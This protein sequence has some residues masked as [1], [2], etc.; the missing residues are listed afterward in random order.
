MP[1][2]LIN[3]FGEL[4]NFVNFFILGRTMDFTFDMK[5]A[6]IVGQK[7]ADILQNEVK[8]KHKIEPSVDNEGNVLNTSSSPESNASGWKKPQL[9]QV[10]FL[11]GGALSGVLFIEI[12][13]KSV[14]VCV[15]VN[16]AYLKVSI[17]N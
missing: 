7:Q 14:C 2:V 9:S 16:L 4:C 15:G 12:M 17:T 6:P 10:E 11:S 3:K 1:F 13:K 5:Q 8:D